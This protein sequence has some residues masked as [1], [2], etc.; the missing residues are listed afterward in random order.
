VRRA[1]WRHAGAPWRAHAPRPHRSQHHGIGQ[2]YALFY[3]ARAAF[4][5]LRGN[6]KLALAVY[7]AGITRCVWRL[8]VAMR[9]GLSSAWPPQEC[10][11]AAAA[12][13]QV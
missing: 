10:A 8:L 3:E 7:E 5:E 12:E 9:V 1:R 13:D 6:F 4:L 11:A 2:E